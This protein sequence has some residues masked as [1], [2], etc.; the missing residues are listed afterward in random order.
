MKPWSRDDPDSRQA[1]IMRLHNVLLTM[2]SMVHNLDDPS[3]TVSLTKDVAPP[4]P[5]SSL[6]LR[7]SAAAQSMSCSRSP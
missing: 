4:G 7:S 5:L 2:S 1:G 6:W 3:G